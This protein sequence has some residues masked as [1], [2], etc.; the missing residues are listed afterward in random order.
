MR[1]KELENIRENVFVYE[2][3]RERGREILHGR[4]G[5]RMRKGRYLV[6]M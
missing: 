1:E 4:L 2:S 5:D 6:E 3:E